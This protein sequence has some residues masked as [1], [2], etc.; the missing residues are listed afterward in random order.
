MIRTWKVRGLVL[1]TAAPLLGL[2]PVAS[3]AEA[4]GSTRTAHTARQDGAPKPPPRPRTHAKPK[5]K[6]KSKT[7]PESKPGPEKPRPESKPKA[8]HGKPRPMHV[9]PKPKPKPAEPKPEPRPKSKPKPKH[10]KPRGEHVVA[11]GGVLRTVAPEKDVM[12]GRVYEWTWTFQA[13][14]KERP[15]AGKAKPVKAKPGKAKPGKAKS[16]KG[17]GGALPIRR[18]K[19]PEAV[20]RATL[21]KSLAFVSGEKDCASSGRTVVCRLGA[22]RPGQKVGGVLRAKVARRA[23]PGRK[24]RPRGTVTWGG[25]RVTRWFPAVRVA[26]VADL[27]ITKTAPA[28]ARA[29]AEIPY[30][31]RVRNLGPSTAESV[32]VQSRGPIKL[33][34]RD[35]AC[36]PRRG[37]YVCSVGALRAGESRT[38]HLK[39]VPRRSVRAG[40]VLESSWTAA[41][42]TADADRA[43]NSAVARTRITGRR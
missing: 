4:G 28:K 37:A 9:H 40:T 31:M 36:L 17:K 33:V 25:T 15:K 41:S 24:I 5:P 10:A 11:K 19:A 35:T 6:P 20:F 42:P 34:G 43:N 39:A 26:A 29:G 32:T 13:T 21:P 2:V 30:E 1:L 8:K 38:L 12:P 22:V 18:A 27:A 7:K 23:E 14:S 3:W 16:V